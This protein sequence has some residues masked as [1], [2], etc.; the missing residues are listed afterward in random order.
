MRGRICLVEDEALLRETTQ[1]DLEDLGFCVLS[2][3]SCDE[4][5]QAI[6]SD[7][8]FDALVTDIRTP[9]DWDGWELAARARAAR[10]GL[11]VVYVTGYSAE[12][13]RPVPGSIFLTKPYRLTELERA[14]QQVGMQ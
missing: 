14:L 3:M 10:P 2:V 4:A 5:W 6:N 1:A 13:P 7:K 12:V 9:G 11:S 8:E